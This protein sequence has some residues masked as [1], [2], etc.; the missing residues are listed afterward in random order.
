MSHPSVKV[1]PSEAPAVIEALRD[2]VFDGQWAVHERVRAAV[3]AVVRPV[4]SDESHRSRTRLGYQQLRE[5]VAA[6]G[7]SSA[8]AGNGPT[9]F[10]LFDWSAVAAPDLFPLLS[11]HFSLAVGSVQRLGDATPEQRQALARLE[12]AGHVGVL[13]LTELG[14]GSNVVEMR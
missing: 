5:V 10:A 4:R 12:D 1:V 11:G 3:A 2:V 8:V 6:L 7:P 9:V 14:Y 13:L